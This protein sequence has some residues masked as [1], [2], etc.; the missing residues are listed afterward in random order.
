MAS[1]AA[2]PMSA[3]AAADPGELRAAALETARPLARRAERSPRQGL[4][5]GDAGIGWLLAQLAAA[6]EEDLREPARSRLAAAGTDPGSGIALADGLAGTALA[7]VQGGTALEDRQLV[8]S[9]R[10][11]AGRAAE[12]AVAGAAAETSEYLTGLGGAI[13]VLLRVADGEQGPL[14]DGARAAG[15]A[16][17][18]QARRTPWGWGWHVPDVTGERV[19]PLCGLA[20]GSAGCACALYELAAATGDPHWAEAADASLRYVW[21]WYRPDVTGWPD[22]RALEGRDPAALDQACSATWC[23]GAAGIGLVF[24]RAYELTGDCQALAGASAALQACRAAVAEVAR[25]Q[26]AAP[27]PLDGSLCHGWGGFVE[28]FVNAWEVLAVP[29]HLRAARRTAGLALEISRRPG[30]GLE[31]GD[32]DCKDLDGL[33]LGK[34]GVAAWLLRAADPAAAT[35]ALLVR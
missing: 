28:L 30:A 16:L 18:E 20:H 9:G 2:D 29:D 11:L 35:S 27:S 13:V 32:P 24:L 19:P 26:A 22:L 31:S 15:S 4:Y 34:A 3:R 8:A 7:L 23:H 17:L 12:A 6:G 21:S 1:A 5:A 14:L 25:R 33:F 10:D